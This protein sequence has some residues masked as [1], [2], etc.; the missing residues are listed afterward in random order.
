[1]VRTLIHEIAHYWLVFIRGLSVG[2]G[3]HWPHNLDLFA[4]DSTLMDPMAYAHWVRKDGRE[5]C[6]S[7]N[8][9]LRFSE[10]S[11]YLMGLLPKESVA[12]IS[13][14]IF[15]TIPGD[16]NYN[17]YGPLC[18]D[19]R[20]YRFLSTRTISIQDLININGPRTPAYPQAQRNFR[21]AFVILSS[22]GEPAPS[23]YVTFIQQFRDL[24]PTVWGQ[25]TEGRSGMNVIGSGSH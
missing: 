15:E 12:P 16:Q 19:P 17:T 6:V 21:I 4:G 10:V 18:G 9:A 20:G 5:T 7:Q 14:H 13:E 25:A 2:D 23:A 1:M 11:L 24:L 3:I 8:A 22:Q